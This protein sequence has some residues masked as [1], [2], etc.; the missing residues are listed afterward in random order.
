[1]VSTLFVLAYSTQLPGKTQSLGTGLFIGESA[2]QMM[3]STGSIRRNAGRTAGCTRPSPSWQPEKPE[4]SR[5]LSYSNERRLPYKVRVLSKL[6]A[7]LSKHMPEKVPEDT[8]SIL[9]S[10]MP[11]SVVAV[12]VKPGDTVAEGQEICVIEAMK[13]QNS[14]TAAKTAK[15]GPDL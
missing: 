7:T 9:R 14:M 10:P 15:V 3:D 13:M 6:A 11:G 2:N 4:V 1:M 8:S 12:S 5:S